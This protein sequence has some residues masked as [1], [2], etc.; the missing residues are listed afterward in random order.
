MPCAARL[1]DQVLHSQALPQAKS[2]WWHG[3]LKGALVGAAIV[4]VSAVAVAVT[5]GTGGFGAPFAI[6]AAAVIIGS[7]LRYAQ[8][9][10][11][12][13]AQA[14][15]M[16]GTRAGPIKTGSRNVYINGKAAALACLS[17]VSCQQHGD[18]KR[19]AQGSQTVWIN[20][21]RL[22][23]VGDQGECG[24]VIGEG[25][26]NVFA[27]TPPASCHGLTVGSEIPKGLSDAVD[28]AGKI[29]GYMELAGGLL[30]GGS[31]LLK[32]LTSVRGVLSL[33]FVG[34][35]GYGGSRLATD[36][37]KSHGWSASG[38]M[39]AGDFGGLGGSLVGGGMLAGGARLLGGT[40]VVPEG[41]LSERP[42]VEGEALEPGR[43]TADKTLSPGNRE[44]A[45]KR[46]MRW[47]DMSPGARRLANGLDN[48]LGASRPINS[49]TVH[50][51]HLA[52]ASEWYG[53]ELGVVQSTETG[54]MRV[55]VGNQDNVPMST[56]ADD[57]I[58]AMHTHT[59]AEPQN[60][61]SFR[62]DFTSMAAE[63]NPR[64]EAVVSWEPEVYHI[65]SQRI[66]PPDEVTMS[67]L[68]QDGY[69]VGYPDEV[70][71]AASGR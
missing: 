7:G 68:N 20:G 26:P 69:I 28:T 19:V 46:D 65:D 9:G 36:Y 22:A 33:G 21:H 63:N 66:V 38:Q 41:G 56:L 47:E 34:G 31:G 54:S 52:Q 44:I 14:G 5:V 11:H 35:M 16:Q 15:A 48:T 67:P 30:M 42:A 57:E 60:L 62:R 10:F 70:L 37:A 51:E 61:G 25:S 27:G 13:G 32:A 17:L 43:Y 6:G 53:K 39:M 50:Y 4:A 49:G 23:R 71:Q 12:E 18:G 45:G 64:T 55:I 29:G 59:S 2:G 8:V 1:G 58:F 40:S 3:L 24:F